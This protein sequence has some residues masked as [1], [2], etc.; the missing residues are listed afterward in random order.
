MSKGRT[1][2]LVVLFAINLLN[3][4]DRSMPGALTEPVR[5]EFGL[6]DAQVGLMGSAFIW[7]YAFIGIPLGRVADTWSRRKLLGWGVGIWSLM[8]AASGLSSSFITLLVPRMGVGV[9]EAVCAPTGASWIGDLFPAERRSRA[10]ALF[11]LGFP[12]G[13]ALS[14]FFAGSMADAWGWRAAMVTAAAPALLL[15]PALLML[16]EPTRGATEKATGE[17]SS[18]WVVL[19][20]P[21]MWWIILSGALLNFNM[22]AIATF[23]PAM[24]SRI[25]HV[26]NSRAG[27]GTGITYLVGGSLGGLLA[28]W[29]GDKVVHK[30][31]DGRMLAAAGLALI[32]VPFSYLGII[33]PEGAIVFSVAMLTV[34]FGVLNGYYGLVYA[35][36]QDIVLPTQRASAMAIYFFGMYMAGASFGP[37]LTGTLSD[38]LARRAAAAA[39]SEIV[40]EVFRATG[41]QQAMLVI[42]VLSA[43]LAGVLWIGSRTILKDA[44]RR[45]S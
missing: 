9:G 27:L 6:T 24:L 18:M 20:I 16:E 5:K 37:V 14:F 8:T 25:H 21:T 45:A 13:G 3:F 40:T 1:Y 39:G 44:E 15:I 34:T 4:Y 10:L 38:L 36:I 23:L 26:S 43:V 32:A 30:R 35:A 7:V 29:I 19:K 42:P 22:Y 17:A 41:L 12:I 31:K 28:G 11:M 33:Q 2:S